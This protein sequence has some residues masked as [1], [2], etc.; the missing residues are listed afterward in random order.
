MTILLPMAGAGNRFAIA[1]YKTSKPAIQ[2]SFWK[3]GK[4][5]P[6]VVCAIKDLPNYESASKLLLIDR[7]FHKE[8]GVEE[9]VKKELPHAEFLTIDQL[10]EGQACTCLLARETI[11]NSQ[12]LFIAGCDNGM[13]YDHK[14]FLDMKATADVLVFT[15]RHHPSLKANPKAYGWC[16][17][18]EEGFISKVSVKVPISDKP[19]NDHAVVAS[20]YFKKGSDFVRSAEKMI[21]ENDRVNGEFYA[22]QV[23]NHCLALG[24]RARVFEIERYLGWGTPED[25]ELY[26]NTLIYWKNFQKNNPKVFA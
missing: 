13:I 5:Y 18:D 19:E 2:T 26:E 10:T 7:T 6:M 15:F 9:E 21:A 4:K 20:F 16:A 11:N 17:V 8:A 12:E 25:Y 22:D 24:L 1:G 23:I 3:T 14:K